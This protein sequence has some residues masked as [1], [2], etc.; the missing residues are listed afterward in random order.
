MLYY[1]I[2]IFAFYVQYSLSFVDVHATPSTELNTPF[3]TLSLS[4]SLCIYVHMRVSNSLLVHLYILP[5]PVTSIPNHHHLH[6]TIKNYHTKKKNQLFGCFARSLFSVTIS[7]GADKNSPPK[8]KSSFNGISYFICVRLCLIAGSPDNVKNRKTHTHT[9][10]THFVH[11]L[12]APRKPQH[13]LCAHCT[14]CAPG[15]CL[16]IFNIYICIK[17]LNEGMCAFLVFGFSFSY[18][19]VVVVILNM[20]H[21]SEL[22]QSVTVID[23]SNTL[24]WMWAETVS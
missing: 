9:F 22:S 16:E 11:G 7:R 12:C 13:K 2:H 21:V 1:R 14:L 6:H 24:L 5:L 8:K 3:K 23:L 10:R 15:N 18:F 19:V 17:W 20:T 4:L